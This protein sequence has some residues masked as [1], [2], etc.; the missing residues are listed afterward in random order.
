MVKGTALSAGWAG[1]KKARTDFPSRA[2]GGRH[3]RARTV[4]PRGKR[5][6]L[7]Q[8]LGRSRGGFGSKLHLR[9][10]NGPSRS[11]V[12]LRDQRHLENL[13]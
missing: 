7:C 4:A 6:Q 9:L 8:A 1:A 5:G 11:T 12:E 13:G 3:E 10:T 2:P